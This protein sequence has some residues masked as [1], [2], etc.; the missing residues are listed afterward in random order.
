MNPN[1]KY[2]TAAE[3]Y[4]RLLSAFPIKGTQ[5]SKIQVMRWCS[6]VVAEYLTDPVGL[7]LNTKVQIGEPTSVDDPTL[8]IR[9]NRALVPPDVFKLENV[10]DEAGNKVKNSTYQGEYIQFSTTKTP[11]KCFIDYYSL[12]V[13]A[14]GFP[15]VKRGYE[16]A[17][18]A[19]CVKKMHEEDASVIPPRIQQWRWLQMCQDSDYEIQAAYISW[20][21]LSNNDIEEIHNYIIS[22]EYKFITKRD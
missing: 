16:T 5:I 1:N 20:G 10:F 21:D 8:V 2:F 17:C 6:E 14:L 19:Y 3:I 13:D 22:P 9:S 7:I 12:P 18:F 15:L 11:Q 4:V